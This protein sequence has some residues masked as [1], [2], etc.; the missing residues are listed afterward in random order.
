MTRLPLGQLVGLARRLKIPRN[1]LAQILVVRLAVVV[2]HRVGV[3]RAPPVNEHLGDGPILPAVRPLDRE[4]RAD[5]E[6]ALLRGNRL[7]VDPHDHLAGRSAGAL[8]ECWARLLRLI[9]AACGG[10]A[11]GC[12]RVRV[13]LASPSACT[14]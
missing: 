12:G 2:H 14:R 9:S 7:L 10:D 13:R 6:G 11:E 5:G 1:L 8:R 3:Y 4:A